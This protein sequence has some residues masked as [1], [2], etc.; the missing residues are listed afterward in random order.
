M[1]SAGGGSK[2][3]KEYEVKTPNNNDTSVRLEHPL[4]QQSSVTQV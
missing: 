1:T 2:D 4:H 3:E